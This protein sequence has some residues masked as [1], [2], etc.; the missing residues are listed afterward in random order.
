MN[1]TIALLDT[2]VTKRL[3]IHEVIK[4]QNIAEH[5]WGVAVILI[6]LTKQEPQ[7][8]TAS[9]LKAA[10]LHDCA[11]SLIGDIPY[12]TKKQ[13]EKSDS[14]GKQS[15]LE[16]MED[17]AN[18]KLGIYTELN[19]LSKIEQTL[20]GAAD[21]LDLKYKCLKEHRLGNRNLTDIINNISRIIQSMDL[22]CLSKRIETEIRDLHATMNQEIQPLT[23]R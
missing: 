13:L 9:L 18:I 3:H 19:S 1:S 15:L 21:I 5:S 17:N 7:L 12:F 22:S 8:L 11:E 23:I 10:I 4:E 2:G 14:L 6:G 20:L 16:I